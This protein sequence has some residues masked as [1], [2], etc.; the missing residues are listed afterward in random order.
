V[1]M[2]PVTAQLMMTLAMAYPSALSMWGTIPR[3]LEPGPVCPGDA[4]RTRGGEAL[5]AEN[6][7]TSAMPLS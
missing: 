6:R 5:A 2:P 7:G 1:W 3:W 4:A